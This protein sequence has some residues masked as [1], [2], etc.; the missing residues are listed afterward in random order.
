MEMVSL[1]SLDPEETPENSNT[2]S[3]PDK[4][5]STY[6]SQFHFQC[7]VSL[8]TKN[9]CGVPLTSMVK[10]QSLSTPNGKPSLPDGRKNQMLLKL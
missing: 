10:V 9:Q 1:S 8:E 7:S 3:K 2:K 5:V 6:Q 4:L